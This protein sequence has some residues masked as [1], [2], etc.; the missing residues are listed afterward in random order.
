MNL[1]L[2][3]MLRGECKAYAQMFQGDIHQIKALFL[4]DFSHSNVFNSFLV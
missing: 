4:P 1:N 3:D 2:E